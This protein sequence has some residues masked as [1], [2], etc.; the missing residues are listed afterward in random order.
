MSQSIIYTYTSKSPTEFFFTRYTQKKNM[1]ALANQWK[2]SF[3]I[4]IWSPAPD[5]SYSSPPSKSWRRNTLAKRGRTWRERHLIDF[6][7]TP[8]GRE[9]WQPDYLGKRNIEKLITWCVNL[10]LESLPWLLDGRLTYLFG[11]CWTGVCFWQGPDLKIVFLGI[12][13]KGEVCFGITRWVL[14]FWLGLKKWI[15]GLSGFKLFSF[16]TG[17]IYWWNPTNSRIV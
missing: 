15:G 11:N 8:G 2:T 10:A 16:D 1:S 6:S 12:L 5:M 9:T 13:I 7:G 4:S 3:P 17:T 14:M